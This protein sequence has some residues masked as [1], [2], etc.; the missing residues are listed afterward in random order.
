MLVEM[1]F[2]GREHGF[3]HARGAIFGAILAPE[4]R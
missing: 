4:E 1:L 3:D 2:L